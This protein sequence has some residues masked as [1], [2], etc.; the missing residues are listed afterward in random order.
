MTGLVVAVAALGLLASDPPE[1]AP[2]YEEI[3]FEP[4]SEAPAEPAEEDGEPTPELLIIGFSTF[5]ATWTLCA[6][7]GLGVRDDPGSRRV[8]DWLMVPVIGPWAAIAVLS[9]DGVI[10][11]DDDPLAYLLGWAG[12]LQ[13]GGL[14]A[15]IIGAVVFAEDPEQAETA[16]ETGGFPVAPGVGVGTFVAPAPGGGVAGGLR[17]GLSLD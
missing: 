11:G 1:A 6:G 3:V 14:A 4:A 10:E 5:G 7:I 9:E 16:V 2:E 8:G 15:G 17:L 13:L 12:A